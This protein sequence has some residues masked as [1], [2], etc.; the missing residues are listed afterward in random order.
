MFLGRKISGSPRA[1]TVLVDIL[2][3][4]QC[5]RLVS[6]LR[7]IKYIPVTVHLLSRSLQTPSRLTLRSLLLVGNT[8]GFQSSHIR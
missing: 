3:L 6:V 7:P 8:P 5:S 2:L 1:T 4:Y